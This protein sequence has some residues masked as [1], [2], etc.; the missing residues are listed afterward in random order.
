ME[1]II[2]STKKQN[3][4][5]NSPF[6]M[7]SL[8]HAIRY[9]LCAM[10]FAA[11]VGCA[12][13]PPPKPTGEFYWPEPPD[14]PKIKWVDQW[15]SA[16]DFGG[17]NP[18]LTFLIGEERADV[19]KRPTGVVADSA[20]NVYVAE[21]E[22]G[23][24]F[25]FD[26]EKKT[27]RFLGDGTLAGPAALAIDNRT[28]V[29][30]AAD[31]KKHQI[32]GLDKNNGRVVLTTDA[33]ELKNASGVAFDEAKERL[34]A[35]DSKNHNVKIFDRN[36]KYLL[37]IGK[38]GVE[39]GEFNF[40]TNLAFRD[41]KLYVVDTLNYRVQIFDAEGKFLKKF[42]KIGDSPGLFSRPKGI[43]VDSEGNIYVVDT[44]FYNFQIFDKDGQLLLW[45]GHTGGKDPGAFNLPSGLYVDGRDRIYVADTFNK[46]VQVFQYLKGN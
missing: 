14:P 25:V 6:A 40:P 3:A 33:N 36:G 13:A 44:A 24:I 1:K 35:S 41:G 29:I 39:D 43:G 32:I 27:V 7:Q 4:K 16:Y 11:I 15:S 30:Y 18:L 23:L 5:C 9:A 34:Y 31:V 20:G 26:I 38:R 37:T 42:G 19:L 45:V 12:S 21:P 2:N 17:P 46:R 8:L 28:G 22:R 10:L